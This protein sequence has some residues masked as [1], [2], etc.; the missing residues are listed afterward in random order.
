MVLRLQLAPNLQLCPP[1]CLPFDEMSLFCV[2]Q[3]SG[4]SV[5]ADMP[6]IAA[7]ALEVI[8]VIVE[9]CAIKFT[10]ASPK[11]GSVML[12]MSRINRRIFFM[13]G[14]VMQSDR[15]CIRSKITKS[16]RYGEVCLKNNH[17]NRRSPCAV[18]A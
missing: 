10:D 7:S 16:Y 11:E 13:G 5:I 6:G 3:S 18:V 15:T 17:P 8:S 1:C 2:M 14:S 4:A 9:H 12:R